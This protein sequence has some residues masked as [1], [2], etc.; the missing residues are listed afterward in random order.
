MIFPY[1]LGSDVRQLFENFPITPPNGVSFN[2][3]STLICSFLFAIAH[4]AT[5][6]HPTRLAV[7]FPSL[8]FGWMRRA[9][10]NTLTPAIFH[11]LCNLTIQIMWGF[12]YRSA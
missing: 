3:S 10:G 5:I 4:Y 6:P 8:L 12:Y 7:F 9:Y 2:W 11:A 1:Q